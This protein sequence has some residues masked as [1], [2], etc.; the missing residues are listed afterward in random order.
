MRVTERT[1]IELQVFLFSCFLNCHKYKIPLPT[2]KC[3]FQLNNSIYY[4]FLSDK[5][6]CAT[7]SSQTEVAFCVPIGWSLQITVRLRTV[8][9][10]YAWQCCH[11]LWAI[12]SKRIGKYV[13]FMYII[14]NTLSLLSFWQ[15]RFS[16]SIPPDENV[17][18]YLWVLL[19]I[20]QKLE[21]VI[22]VYFQM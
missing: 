5:P 11:L 19:Q 18:Y 14:P 12:W 21:G 9:C 6:L 20:S 8:W 16:Y 2:W 13:L 4:I 3:W 1:R 22:L 10:N 17:Q 7:S 15:Q